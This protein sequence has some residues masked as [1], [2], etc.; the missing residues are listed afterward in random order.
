MWPSSFPFDVLHGFGVLAMG[1]GPLEEKVHWDQ[2]NWFD[3]YAKL[4]HFFVDSREV[5]CFRPLGL[6]LLDDFH[7]IW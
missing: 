4:W 5:A 1:T 7:D 2:C 6:W 3:L